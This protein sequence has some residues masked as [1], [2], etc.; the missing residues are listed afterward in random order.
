[1]KP[2]DQRRREDDEEKRRREWELMYANATEELKNF[3]DEAFVRGVLSMVR[4]P[5]AT[6]PQQRRKRPGARELIATFE[7]EGLVARFEEG[8]ERVKRRLQ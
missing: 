2:A 1:M 5:H 7:E 6:T 8:R 4:F 3:T